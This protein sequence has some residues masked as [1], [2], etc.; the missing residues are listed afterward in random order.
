MDINEFLNYENF[1]G[2]IKSFKVKP[3]IKYIQLQY[4]KVLKGSVSIQ[5]DFKI[6]NNNLT[7]LSKTNCLKDKNSI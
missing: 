6:L 3:I 1:K 5:K 2:K 7:K 4:K